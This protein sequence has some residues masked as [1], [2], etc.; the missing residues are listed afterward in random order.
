[1][2]NIK[3]IIFCAFFALISYLTCKCGFCQSINLNSL[4]LAII[5]GM[6]LKYLKLK[7]T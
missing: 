6:I 4:T 2:E 5:I 3:G 1:M 7:T